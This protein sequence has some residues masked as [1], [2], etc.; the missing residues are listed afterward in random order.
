MAVSP[1]G[2]WPLAPTLRFGVLS[3]G[4]IRSFEQLCEALIGRCL[5]LLQ[6]QVVAD[7]FLEGLHSDAGDYGPVS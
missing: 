1:W 6:A 2:G 7:R 4:R 5:S 3:R